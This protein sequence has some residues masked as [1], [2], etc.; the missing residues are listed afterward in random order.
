MLADFPGLLAGANEVEHAAADG[1]LRDIAGV[2]HLRERAHIAGAGAGDD[3]SPINVVGLGELR[4]ESLQ[5]AAG[6][7]LHLIRQFDAVGLLS[8]AE[9]NRRAADDLAE[10]FLNAVP[11]DFQM[12]LDGLSGLDG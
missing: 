12:G 4:E 7:I 9:E 11:S 6:G 5:S 10:Q 3:L 2:A 1:M 8:A